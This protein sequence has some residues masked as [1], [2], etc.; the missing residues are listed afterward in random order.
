MDAKGPPPPIKKSTSFPGILRAIATG[1][2]SPE[3]AWQRQFKCRR[4]A[5][6][7]AR[8]A[9]GGGMEDRII[10]PTEAARMTGRSK[11]SLWRDERAGKFP[12]RVRIGANAV[13]WRLSEIQAW[14]AGREIVTGPNEQR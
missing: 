5:F 1:T 10:R 4:C 9:K 8:T 13:G 11:V 7:F 14:I 6:F 12:R 2:A 3:T